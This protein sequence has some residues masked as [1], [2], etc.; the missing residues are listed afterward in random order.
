MQAMDGGKLTEQLATKKLQSVG[1]LFCSY[2]TFVP[3]HIQAYMHVHCPPPPGTIAPVN[4]NMEG[5]FDSLLVVIMF[6]C[7]LQKQTLVS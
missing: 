2:N 5:K 4:T 3:L 6:S 1:T 7:F